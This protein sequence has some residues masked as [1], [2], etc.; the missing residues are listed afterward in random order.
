QDER[1]AGGA[2]QVTGTR[3]LES[4]INPMSAARAEVHDG[5]AGSGR[6]D[7]SSFG[8]ENRLEMNLIDEKCLNELGFEKWREHLHERLTRKHRRAF[9]HGEHSAGEA[10]PAKAIEKPVGKNAFPAQILQVVGAEMQGFEI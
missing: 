1:R 3:D 7:A 6:D 4:G 5:S 10:Q 8:R 2:N 9:R